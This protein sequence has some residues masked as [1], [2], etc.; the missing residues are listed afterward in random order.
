[1]KRFLSVAI[2][3]IVLL[4]AVMVIRSKSD[5]VPATSINNTTPAAE[6]VVELGVHGIGEGQ[7][8][9]LFE[10]YGDFY[11][12][13]SKAYQPIVQQIKDKYG[14]KLRFQ[15]RDY[16][17]PE[18]VVAQAAQ[19]AADAAE[20]Q[21]SFWQMHEL[22]Y[23]RQSDWKN[24]A[25]PTAIFE[26]YAK[27]LGLDMEQYKLDVKSKSVENTIKTDQKAGRAAQVVSAP[28]FFIDGKVVA[29]DMDFDGFVRLID[30]AIVSNYQPVSQ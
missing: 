22:L 3:A 25:D 10:E 13:A 18:N 29:A 5:V 14:D 1:M 2:V 30:E 9:V 7:T 27:E 16:A 21:G 19:K 6:E 4:A 20:I 12:E 15:Y 24:S 17:V 23:E 28:T 11:S 26:S 8:G